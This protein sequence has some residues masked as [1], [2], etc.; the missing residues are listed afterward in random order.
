MAKI[1]FKIQKAGDRGRSP[2]EIILETRRKQNKQAGPSKYKVFV[3]DTDEVLSALD[4]LLKRSK[5]KL[6]SI[7][8][9]KIETHK[10][11]GLT[12]TRIIKSIIKAL[13]LSL[14]A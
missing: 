4:T 3:Q 13:C 1:I 9:I 8:D 12:S 5:M 14:P 2:I 6:E 7:K 11:A 10:K